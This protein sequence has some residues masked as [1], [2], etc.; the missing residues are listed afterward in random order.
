[1]MIWVK[2]NESGFCTGLADAHLKEEFSMCRLNRV[3][4][5]NYR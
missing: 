2:D 5:V 3:H 4:T 1:M